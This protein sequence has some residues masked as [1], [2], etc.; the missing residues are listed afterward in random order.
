MATTDLRICKSNP[1]KDS[2]H[3]TVSVLLLPQVG[4]LK[5]VIAQKKTESVAKCFKD[6][7]LLQYLKKN[8]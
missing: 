4:M 3:N 7:K 6:F 2:N 8:R 1:K 5:C